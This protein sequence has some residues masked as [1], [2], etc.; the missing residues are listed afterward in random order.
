MGFDENQPRDPAGTSTGGQWTGGDAGDAIRAAAGDNKTIDSKIDWDFTEGKNYLKDVIT[1]ELGGEKTYSSVSGSS[2]Y[3][4]KLPNSLESLTI[5]ISNHFVPQ[6]IAGTRV[7]N[8][9][10]INLSNKGYG[11]DFKKDAPLKDLKE[12][13]L[14]NVINKLEDL[15]S[16]N[17]AADIDKDQK[18]VETILNKHYKDKY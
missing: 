12:H 13:L 18:R 6:N 16:V 3:K 11:L 8:D 7:S 17:D 1:N 10:N 15:R 14:V 4:I 2:Y 9:I 5:R